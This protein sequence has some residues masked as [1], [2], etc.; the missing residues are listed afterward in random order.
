MNIITILKKLKS[1]LGETKEVS[2]LAILCVL[3]HKRK[4][5]EKVRTILWFGAYGNTNIGDNMVFFAIRKYLPKDVSILLSNRECHQNFDYGA[6]IF[7]FYDKRN[8]LRLMKGSQI[9]L[10]GGG[11]LFEYYRM[12]SGSG[13]LL[14]YLEP[15][16]YARHLGKSYAIVGV[17]CNNMVIR[18]SVIRYI[19]RKVSNDASFI[20]TRD[21]KSREGFT[22]N[23]VDNQNLKFCFDP[24]FTYM[25]IEKEENRQL[26]KVV[27]FLVWPFYMWPHF[28]SVTDSI[29]IIRSRMTKE[30][31]LAHDRFLKELR[32]CV[33]RLEGKG[34]KCVFPVF[35]FSDIILHRELGVRSEYNV[36][37]F[38]DYLKTIS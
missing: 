8:W 37:S 3:P 17:G 12:S 36:P 16:V 30:S 18:N 24:V 29:I 23:G 9:V 26:S 22:K 31:I 27:G 13:W 4:K 19:F 5:R 21:Q 35:H 15:L 14:R 6:T 34:I 32:A 11:G 10:L 25:P 7:Y 2:K 28:H 38:D 20:I 1:K 33:N